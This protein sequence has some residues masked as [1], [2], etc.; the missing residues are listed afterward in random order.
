L[1]VRYNPQRQSRTF[2][3][4]ASGDPFRPANVRR[5]LLET[6]RAFANRSAGAERQFARRL[7]ERG[8]VPGIVSSALAVVWPRARR[9]HRAAPPVRVIGERND[10]GF[11]ACPPPLPSERSGPAYQSP[12]TS[13]ADFDR[14]P[15][16][17]RGLT[18]ITD[19]PK[20]R[21][22]NSRNSSRILDLHGLA[23]RA[24][25]E[26]R[27]TEQEFFGLQASASAKSF[28]ALAEAAGHLV[29][30]SVGAFAWSRE[31]SPQKR[32]P[33]MSQPARRC[34]RGPWR[35]LSWGALT[36]SAICGRWCRPDRGQRAAFPGK[37]SRTVW[38]LRR[39]FPRHQR[40]QVRGPENLNAA[41]ESRALLRQ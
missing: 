15:P 14:D 8:G 38:P 34:G 18:K 25:C 6:Q 10:L 3:Q 29:R 2:S 39:Q 22:A 4:D 12:Q 35:L 36:V 28:A 11:Q 37:I 21:A 17:Y 5:Q 20:F 26:A 1:H 30:I 23:I 27:P 16:Q 7:V 40:Q 9:S 19:M 24:P 32:S 33:A 41:L 13:V 31:S